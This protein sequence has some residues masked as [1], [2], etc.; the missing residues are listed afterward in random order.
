MSYSLLWSR[1]RHN[2]TLGGDFRRQQFNYLSQQNPRGTF[3]FTGAAT[4]GR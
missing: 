2:I 1:D 3:T 4:A